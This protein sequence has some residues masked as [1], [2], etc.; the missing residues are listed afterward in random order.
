[1]LVEEV[2]EDLQVEQEVVE[3]VDF[4]LVASLSVCGATAYP[5]TVGGGGTGNNPTPAPAFPGSPSGQ[6]GTSGSP[7]IFSAITSTG[8]GAGVGVN[9]PSSNG[10][11][12]GSGLSGGSGGGG[13][14]QGPNGG[15]RIAGTGNTPPVSPPQGNP[16]GF[17][18]GPARF[19][20][21]WRWWSR[22]SW[23]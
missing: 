16:G 1:L 19:W 4:E 6:T 17:S 23:F 11:G 9:A 12:F 3:Q 22:S 18:S 21:R 2:V 15:L 7:S 10:P 5:I 13:A 8:G 14:D 20:S